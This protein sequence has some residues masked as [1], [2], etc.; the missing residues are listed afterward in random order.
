MRG[1]A[2]LLTSSAGSVRAEIEALA[3]KMH[4]EV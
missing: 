3:R 4:V 2:N 1:V